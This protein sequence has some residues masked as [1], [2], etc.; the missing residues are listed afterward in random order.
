MFPSENSDS[1]KATADSLK[2]VDQY[3]KVYFTTETLVQIVQSKSENGFNMLYD[4]YCGTL[5][6]ILM[7]FVKK[8]NVA[9]DLLHEIFIKIWRGIDTYNPEKGTVFRWMMNITRN[10]AIDYIRSSSH[11]LELHQLNKDLVTLQSDDSNSK[12]ASSK[13]I[14]Y[15]GIKSKTLQLSKKY[16]DVVDLIFFYGCTYE[17]TARIMKLSVGTIKT[18]A[19][20]GLELLKILF[21]QQNAK[22]S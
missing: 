20:K 6:S 1:R 12:A 7:K 21:Q 13:R 5:Y 22:A 14:K 19:R 8:Q 18:R 11:P 4:K 10:Q 17:Q 15:K 16:A 2:T 9:D 3:A